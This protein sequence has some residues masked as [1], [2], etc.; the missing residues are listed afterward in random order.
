M[1]KAEIRA[2]VAAGGLGTGYG[3]RGSQTDEKME[4]REEGTTAE[5]TEDH[6]K[7]LSCQRRGRSF[8]QT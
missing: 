1:A 5:N 2:R 6:I 7:A 3:M 4:R 8:Q